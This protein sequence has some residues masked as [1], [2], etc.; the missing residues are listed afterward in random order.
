MSRESILSRENSAC[1]EAASINTR[2]SSQSP[3]FYHLWVTNSLGSLVPFCI[4]VKI[5]K[6]KRKE[7]HDIILGKYNKQ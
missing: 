3:S 4:K 7:K 1:P 5:P 6:K 2:S